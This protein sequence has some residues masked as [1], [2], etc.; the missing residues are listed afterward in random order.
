MLLYHKILVPTLAVNK[1]ARF[2]YDILSKYEGG[3][4]LSGAE[5][6][7]A[8][9]GSIN[10]KGAFLTI[11][12]NQLFLKNMHIG[13]Y[14][15]AGEQKDYDPTH[16]RKVLVHRNEINTLIGKKQADGLTILPISVYTKGDLVKLEFGVGRGKKKYEKRESLKKRSIEKQMR[17]ELK[18]TR[19]K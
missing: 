11:Q 7:A 4:V 12:N 3:L 10:L 1:R 18:K 14:A 13:K 2:D 5:V 16:D 9:R 8:K 19:F 6:K 17:E 15:P